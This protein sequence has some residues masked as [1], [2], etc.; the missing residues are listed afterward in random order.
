[1][2]CA[3]ESNQTTISVSSSPTSTGPAP[4]KKEFEDILFEEFAKAH[5]GQGNLFVFPTTNVEHSDFLEN[6]AYILGI[7][8]DYENWEMNQH[9]ASPEKKV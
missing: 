3:N 4:E 6:L 9:G 2:C 7:G 8:D 1:M 5:R